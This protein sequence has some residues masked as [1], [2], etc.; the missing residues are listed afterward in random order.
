MDEREKAIHD[1]P[2]ACSASA[3]TGRFVSQRRAGARKS[4]ARAQ[5][6]QTRVR[7]LSRGFYTYTGPIPSGT[8]GLAI[9]TELLY[10]QEGPA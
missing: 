9:T 3:K 4:P 8:E 6:A 10:G 7:P 1:G 5:A 2:A